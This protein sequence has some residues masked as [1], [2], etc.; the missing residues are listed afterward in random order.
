MHTKTLYETAG[1][2]SFGVQATHLY[3]YP[4]EDK[5]S[6][7]H[8]IFKKIMRRSV[9]GFC[10]LA[11]IFFTGFVHLQK[12]KNPGFSRAVLPFSSRAFLGLLKPGMKIITF[13]MNCLKQN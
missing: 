1:H 3:K 2:A 11:A 5:Y 8:K 12:F 7:S 6:V 10:N 13:A 9:L 4:F